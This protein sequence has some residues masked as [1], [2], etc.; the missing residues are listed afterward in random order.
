MRK[1]LLHLLLPI[2]FVLGA[3]AASAQSITYTAIVEEV[4]PGTSPKLMFTALVD[5]LPDANLSHEEAQQLLVI[6]TDSQ[7]SFAE[8]HALLLPTGFILISL[9]EN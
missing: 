2:L 4:E 9:Q 1:Y 6:H 7:I 8:L 3:S 5:M